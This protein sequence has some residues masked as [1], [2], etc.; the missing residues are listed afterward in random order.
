MSDRQLGK[1][2]ILVVDDLEDN[3][4]LLSALLAAK[5]YEVEA[6]NSGKLAIEAIETASPD[7]ILLDVWMPEMDGYEVCKVLKANPLTKDIPIIFISA[8]NKAT[9]KTQAFDAGGDDYITKPFQIEEVVARVE[10]QLS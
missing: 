5:G 10:H 4:Y 6:I 9:D 8:L 1:K 3:L 2:K 7:I